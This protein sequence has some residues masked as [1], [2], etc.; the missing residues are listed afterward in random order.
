MLLIL[1]RYKVLKDGFESSTSHFGL[2]VN[3]DREVEVT[4]VKYSIGFITF[5][6]RLGGIIGVGKELLWVLISLFTV[7][8]F[9]LKRILKVYS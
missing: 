4:E 8:I 5:L 1:F 3:F 9:V 7:G 2:I 6:T